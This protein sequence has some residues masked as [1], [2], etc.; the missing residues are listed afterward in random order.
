VNRVI[1]G[2]VIFAAL[3]YLGAVGMIMV[4][5]ENWMYRTFVDRH[6][7]MEKTQ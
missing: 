4:A 3:A 1:G 7:I 5:D 2:A 6:G